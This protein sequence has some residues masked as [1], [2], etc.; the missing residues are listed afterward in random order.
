MFDNLLESMLMY[1]A[2]TSEW[3]E[4]QRMDRVHAAYLTLILEVKRESLGYVIY[5]QFYRQ[6]E[7]FS[8]RWGYER[9]RSE[10][11]AKNILKGI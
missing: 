4:Q 2:E 5:R 8:M 10:T 9:G 3:K 1:G 11:R 6:R 7:Q